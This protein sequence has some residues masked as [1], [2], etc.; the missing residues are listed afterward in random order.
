MRCHYEVLGIDKAADD[1]AIK[2][3]YHKLALKYHPDK[4]VVDSKIATERFKE[5]QTAYEVL[6][7]KNERKWYDDHRTA[8][9]S[10]KSS[11]EGDADILPNIWPYFSSSCFD[12][13][14]DNKENGFYKVYG[15][16]FVEINQ[17]EKNYN[18]DFVFLPYFGDSRTSL[19]KVKRFY[20]EW[21]NYTSSLSFAW[22]DV[23][24]PN[25]DSYSRY[26]KRMIG[27]ENK[28][29]REKEKLKFVKAIRQ[30]VNFVSKRDPRYK[31]IIS[32][33]A[34]IRR[35]RD[36]E[37]KRREKEIEARKKQTRKLLKENLEIELKQ[38]ELEEDRQGEKYFKLA[39][40]LASVEK[41]DSTKNFSCDIC[42]KSFK[43]TKQL[44]NHVL[45]K[46]HKLQAKK[47][48]VK[49]PI[50]VVRKVSASKSVVL[51][52]KVVED[53][54]PLEN[55]SSS[56]STINFEDFSKRKPLKEQIYDTS[57]SSGDHDDLQDRMA[58]LEFDENTVF[59]DDKP[60]SETK[61]NFNV[62]AIPITQASKK[63]RRKK[64]KGNEKH[65]ICS[66]CQLTFTT[67]NQLFQHLKKEGHEA[68]RK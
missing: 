8:I 15:N 18:A 53:T 59:V 33:T 60:V 21:K 31:T 39:D 13:Y 14:D 7:D 52:K 61:T 24:N 49:P 11:L 36:E 37:N 58:T 10:G 28:K 66:T 68:N 38:R 44:Q 50:N 56:D 3:A 23:A 45:S 62:E 67:R 40:E 25:D 4:N 26:Q 19:E 35:R 20:V 46:K 55:E 48:K 1:S 32:E 30:L 42:R 47:F 63:S 6:K 41:K 5:L 9:L 27:K 51:N 54:G 57:S 2:K 64:N 12:G 16:M 29:I 43:S 34:D 65:L 22:H 17:V